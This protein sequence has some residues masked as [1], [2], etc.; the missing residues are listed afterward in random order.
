VTTPDAGWYT[1][2]GDAQRV[3]WW[4]G[5]GWTEH[6]RPHPEAVQPVAPV[7]HVQPAYP[8]QPAFAAQ[9]PY[10]QQ[11]GYDPRS[12][13]A[14]RRADRERQMR[15]NNPWAYTGLLLTLIA[16]LINPFSVLSLLGAG[17][18]IAGLVR[19][20]TVDPSVRYNGRVTA[21]IGLVIALLA[22]GF[23]WVRWL[24]LAG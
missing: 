6:V 19:A 4:N 1:D 17:F 9:Q 3:R 23:F 21:I 18:S 7:Y 5:A 24:Q 10:P 8:T 22:T 15:R 11:Y 12:A 16:L 2:P 20:A 14:P 13:V